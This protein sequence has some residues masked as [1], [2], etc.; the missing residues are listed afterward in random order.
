MHAPLQEQNSGPH[1][2]V[3]KKT[4]SNK[5]LT[6]FGIYK[7]LILLYQLMLVSEGAFQKGISVRS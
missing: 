5:G 2:I 6:L 3:K 7:R 1:R 4:M